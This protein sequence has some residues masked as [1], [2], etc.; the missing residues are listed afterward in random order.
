MM[1]YFIEPEWN[2][3]AVDWDAIHLTWGGF[4]TTEGLV[5]DLPDGDVATLRN[6]CSERTLWLNPVLSEPEP[7]PRPALSGRIDN[8][9]GLDPRT[10]ESRLAQDLD[11]LRY[12]LGH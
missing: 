5:I 3:V 12:R 1:R 6:W 7:L 2:A 10:D 4:L 9:S 11:W 8:D